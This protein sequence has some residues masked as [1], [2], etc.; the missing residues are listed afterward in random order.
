MKKRPKPRKRIVAAIGLAA[1]LLLSAQG[2]AAQTGGVIHGTVYVDANANL[3]R[4]ANEP[5]LVGAEVIVA[6]GQTGWQLVTG[7]DGTYRVDVPNGTW[8]VALM[9]PPGYA[10]ANDA[11]REV[12]IAPESTLD[13]TMDFA[14]L[15]IGGGG[16]V[17]LPD[18]QVP[19]A[20]PTLPPV[21]P[22]TG[23][24]LAPSAAITLGLAGLLATGLLLLGFGRWAAKRR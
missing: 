11:T 16:A 14:L 4:D 7:A 1:A 24:S 12:N 5:P 15:S 6:N 8:Q 17:P 22:Q 20:T 23:A 18:G 3:V 13:A 9:V 10:P 2:A 19:T 21:L